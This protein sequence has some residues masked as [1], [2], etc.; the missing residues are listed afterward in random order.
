MENQTGLLKEQVTRT[1]ASTWPLL[2]VIFAIELIGQETLKWAATTAC[3]KN[4]SVPISRSQPPR[5]NPPMQ[6]TLVNPSGTAARI[7]R[8]KATAEYKLEASR[9]VNQRWDG[10]CHKAN[11]SATDFWHFHRSLDKHRSAQRSILYDDEGNIL[12]SD[13]EQGEAFLDRFIRQSDHNDTDERATLLNQLGDLCELAACDTPILK[14]EV[15]DAI[16]SSKDGA[17]GPDGIKAP[18]LK[19]L[20]EETLAHLTKS[21]GKSWQ[22]GSIPSEWTDA[23]LAPVP[24]P[25]KNH[26]LLKGYRIIVMQNL[27]GKIP[28]KIIARRITKQIEAWLPNGMG[29]YRP[30]RETWANAASLAADIWEGFENHQK[31]L[32]VALDLEDAYNSVRLPILADGMLHLGISAGCVRWVMTALRKR[33]CMLKHGTWR[34]N[35]I[36]IS[37]GLPQGSPLSPVLFNIYT[38]PLARINHADCRLRTFADDIITC[39]I[40][41]SPQ[42][43]V[44]RTQ[45][46]RSRP[47]SND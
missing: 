41:K 15:I 29:A 21:Y 22:T 42:Q 38:L 40:G 31:A 17:P 35:W 4:K 34:S 20:P 36:D 12:R 6:D 33:R 37:T 14:E 10:L 44:Q 19:S 13:Q 24:K 5:P 23:F 27:V 30:K 1:R 7:E 11:L 46:I 28:E 26:K 32:L 2:V 9:A 47:G 18:T 8:N 3:V 45:P 16:N 25:G 39:A 43:L